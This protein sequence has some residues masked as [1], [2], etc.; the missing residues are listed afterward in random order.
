MQGQNYRATTDEV[1]ALPEVQ[2]SAISRS[3]PFHLNQSASRLGIPL[4]LL[5]CAACL[6]L[7]PARETPMTGSKLLLEKHT[8]TAQAAYL[9]SLDLVTLLKPSSSN[10][11]LDFTGILNDVNAVVPWNDTS[12]QKRTL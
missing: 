7:V 2:C 11:Y 12:T 1:L 5:H 10:T 9:I 6:K 4:H 8:A 3:L